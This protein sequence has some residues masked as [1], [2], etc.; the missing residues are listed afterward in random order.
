[1]IFNQELDQGKLMVAV[2]SLKKRTK[3]GALHSS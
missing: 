2:D 3:K 1:M